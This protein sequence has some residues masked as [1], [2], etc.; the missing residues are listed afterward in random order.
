MRTGCFL[1]AFSLLWG[2]S[3]TRGHK[4]FA[5]GNTDI[6]TPISEIIAITEKRFLIPGTVDTQESRTLP[7]IRL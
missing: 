5:V 4:C 7:G 6:P 1:P 3:P 2:G